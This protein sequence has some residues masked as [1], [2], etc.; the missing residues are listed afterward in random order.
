MILAVYAN[1]FFVCLQ[2]ILVSKRITL[3]DVHLSKLG[4]ISVLKDNKICPIRVFRALNPSKKGSVYRN[5]FEIR[6]NFA[7]T[8]EKDRRRLAV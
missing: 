7:S 5:S 6:Y 8:S 4:P 1:N 3:S 2:V